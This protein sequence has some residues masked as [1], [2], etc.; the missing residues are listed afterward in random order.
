MT[1]D[2]F[3]RA[4]PLV[5]AFFWLVGALRLADARPRHA[6]ALHRRA[7]VHA[8]LAGASPRPAH[9]AQRG[10][11]ASFDTLYTY[12]I[13]PFWWIGNVA[14]R[15]I[16]RSSTSAS[17]V[18]TSAIFPTYFLA[19]MVVSRGLGAV[20]RRRVPSS[21]PALAYASFL[22]EEPARLSRSARSPLPDREGARRPHP[23]VADRRRRAACIVGGLVRGRARDPDRRLRARG[24]LR[25]PGRARRRRPGGG[26]GATWDWVGAVVLGI[27]AI[28]L[29]SAIIG[30]PL[31]DVADR[32]RLL[33]PPDDRLRPV[34][35][36]RADD[37]PRAAA[38]SSGSRRSSGHGTSGGRGS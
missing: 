14:T 2:R 6:L 3:Y 16:R 26:P 21:T 31:A 29:F 12:F 13:A 1:R 5:G 8:D 35:G 15:P 32:D 25:S 18:M 30:R 34:G 27:G 17:I 38:R 19:R 7:Q 23:L 33:P 24:D 22:L 28:I 37:R 4:I 20:R 9:P 11:P 36:R 10:H